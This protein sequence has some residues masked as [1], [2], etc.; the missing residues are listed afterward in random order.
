MT[1]EDCRQ[2]NGMGRE[3]KNMVHALQNCATAMPKFGTCIMM[4]LWSP[5]AFLGRNRGTKEALEPRLTMFILA[6]GVAVPSPPAH[7]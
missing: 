3:R 2:S 7:G 1:L 6:V 4:L 5:T